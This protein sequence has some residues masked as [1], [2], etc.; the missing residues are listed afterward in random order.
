MKK[1]WIYV[2]AGLLAVYLIGLSYKKYKV[3]YEEATD[4]DNKELLITQVLISK[5]E[6]DTPQNRAKYQGMSVAELEKLL[7]PDNMPEPIDVGPEPNDTTGVGDF[8]ET[9]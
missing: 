6:Q 5:N 1:T 2:A 8:Y 4:D 7:V 9:K 3:D